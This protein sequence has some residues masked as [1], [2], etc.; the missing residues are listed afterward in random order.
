MSQFR[1]VVVLPGSPYPFGDVT[2]R[3]SFPLLKGLA[4]RGFEVRCLSVTTRADWAAGARACLEPLGVSLRCFAPRSARSWAAG[5]LA[6]F[7]E[8]YSYMLSDELRRAVDEETARGYDVL[9]LEQLWSG[10]L[11][12]G[13]VRTLTSVHY[14]PSIDLHGEWQPSLRFFSSK[15]L[16]CA[17]ERRLLKSL[18]HIRTLT[19]RLA[20]AAA[21]VNPDIQAHTVPIAIDPELFPFSPE[22]RYDVPVFGFVGNMSW[23]PGYLSAVRLIT[24]ILPRVR[25]RIPNARVLLAGWNA[26]RL[27]AKYLDAPGVE[28]V[29]DVQDVRPYFERLQALAYPLP[30]GS[31]MMVKV[32]EAMAYGIPVVTTSEGIE[33]IDADHSVH[34]LLADDDE[35]FAEQVVGALQD[36]ALRRRLRRHA[37]QLVQDRYSPLATASAL[38]RLYQAL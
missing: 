3:W 4:K 2:G 24:R 30:K 20:R 8:P 10:Y 37:R 33:G 12:P 35:A 11:A 9:Q 22:D 15:Y 6:T 36:G 34:A 18:V 13:R 7:R 19:P 29:Q 27:L 26:R 31:G 17:T 14:L 28:I 1:V 23:N 38:E 25:M 32:L 16:M 21:G 5:K